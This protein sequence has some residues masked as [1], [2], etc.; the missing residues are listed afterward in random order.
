MI[1]YILLL[2]TTLTFSQYISKTI[3]SN[4]YDYRDKLCDVRKKKNKQRHCKSV[5][6]VEQRYINMNPGNLKNK[7]FKDF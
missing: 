2:L 4:P 7:V 6:G 3:K 1:Q 5:I